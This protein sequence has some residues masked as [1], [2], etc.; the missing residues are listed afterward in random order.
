MLSFGAQ[1]YWINLQITPLPKAGEISIEK[2]EIC[3]S[4]RTR[5][6]AIGMPPSAMRF[7]T[8]A[9]SSMWLPKPELKKNNTN[10]WGKT[11]E[12]TTLQNI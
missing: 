11:Q 3:E 10:E 12:D 1:S 7:Y 5:K 4:Q 9:V 6:F 8:H 2:R